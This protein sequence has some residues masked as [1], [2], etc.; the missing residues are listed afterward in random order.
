LPRL[1]SS[2][3]GFILLF[4]FVA[5][6]RI[7]LVAIPLEERALLTKFGEEYRGYMRRT[8]RLWP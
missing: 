8:G 3:G 7:L 5:L 6:V 4:A 2:D 1:S